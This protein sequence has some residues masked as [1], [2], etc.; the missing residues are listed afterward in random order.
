MSKRTLFSLI[1]VLLFVLPTCLS[2]AAVE[3]DPTPENPYLEE[4]LAAKAIATAKA[5][6]TQIASR[7][8]P[9]A[10][11]SNEELTYLAF[12]FTWSDETVFLPIAES[13]MVNSG[14]ASCQLEPGTK[15]AIGEV[16]SGPKF[17]QSKCVDDEKAPENAF[18]I[19]RIP[20]YF[21][22]GIEIGSLNV[23]DLQGGYAE[24]LSDVVTVIIENDLLGSD[25]VTLSIHR[26]DGLGSNPYEDE[27]AIPTYTLPAEVL[28]IT[29]SDDHLGEFEHADDVVYAL[30]REFTWKVPAGYSDLNLSLGDEN[31]FFL[32]IKEMQGGNHQDTEHLSGAYI[33]V[34]G[35][36]ISVHPG[37]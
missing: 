26:T 9:Y 27:D 13:V 3:P 10:E 17:E 5:E 33:Q 36:G 16:F 25:D 24:N 15:I 14:L 12:W 2:T 30:E 20:G 8:S 21:D 7:V 23:I 28:Q 31:W 19:I 4:E 11:I 22:E 37:D 32:E 6:K 18:P 34:R 29:F 35:V 1:P